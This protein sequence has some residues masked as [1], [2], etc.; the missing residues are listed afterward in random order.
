MSYGK[1]VSGGCT[2]GFII[3]WPTIKLPLNKLLEVQ[4]AEERMVEAY[5]HASLNE[6]RW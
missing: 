4:E 6:R 1:G 2:T 3:M 5:A